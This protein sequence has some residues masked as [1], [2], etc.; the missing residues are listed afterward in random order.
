MAFM[1]LA[2]LAAAAPTSDYTPL[3]LERCEIV[4][5]AHAGE[6][7]WMNRRCRG[8][9]GVTLFVSEDDG[10]FDLDAGVDNGEWESLPGFNRLGAQVEWRI[11]GHRPFA[12]IY[13]YLPTDT[14]QDLNTML[15][16]ESIGRPGRPGCLVALIRSNPAANSRARQIADS[17]ARSFR[18]GTDQPVRE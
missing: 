3:N 17:R 8:R 9:S 18:C 12:V 6:G 4:S 5:V 7:E 16:V 2:A 13:R 1:L 11:E 15:A 14:A 10:R